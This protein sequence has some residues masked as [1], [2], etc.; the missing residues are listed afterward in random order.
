MPYGR[1]A[2]DAWE[3]LGAALNLG[4]EELR[5]LREDSQK[6]I[7]Q[8]IDRR[9]I[10]TQ[11]AAAGYLWVVYEDTYPRA[12]VTWVYVGTETVRM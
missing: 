12:A 3:R 2:Q 10:R 11:L 1:Q 5:D 8:A 9:K 6:L 7:E 4:Y